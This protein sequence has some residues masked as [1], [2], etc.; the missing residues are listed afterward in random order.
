M[1]KSIIKDVVLLIVI[2]AEDETAWVAK[3]LWERL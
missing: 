3:Q 2:D 1:Y